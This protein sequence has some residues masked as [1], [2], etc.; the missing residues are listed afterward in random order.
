M[1]QIIL[2]WVTLNKK[3][4]KTKKHMKKRECLSWRLGLLFFCILMCL[5]KRTK[6]VAEEERG[7]AYVC[8]YFSLCISSSSV[9]RRYVGLTLRHHPLLISAALSVGCPLPLPL[10]F[11]S[12]SSATAQQPHRFTYTRKKAEIFFFFHSFILSSQ[13]CLCSLQ[14]RP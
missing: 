14:A 11:I 2:N 10:L 6:K 5:R 9:M 13:L 7:C 4:N 3:K 8:V 1:H 12:F